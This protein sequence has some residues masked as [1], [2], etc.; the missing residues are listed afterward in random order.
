MPFSYPGSKIYRPTLVPNSSVYFHLDDN[1]GVEREAH[2]AEGSGERTNVVL[3]NTRHR[4]LEKAIF[5]ECKRLTAKSKTA[6]NDNWNKTVSQLQNYITGSR[7]TGHNTDLYSIIAITHE[8]RFYK[9]SA[10]QNELESWSGGLF[11]RKT[12]NS[13]PRAILG[14]FTESCGDY[15][16]WYESFHSNLPLWH[17][18]TNYD[19]LQ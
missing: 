6:N 12:I 13:Q 3:T 1:Y 19:N 16:R 17:I 18:C 2:T 15:A 14:T 5:V 4:N 7:K 9:L 8:T 10:A 11:L